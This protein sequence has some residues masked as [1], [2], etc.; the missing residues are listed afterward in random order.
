MPNS[1]TSIGGYAFY[2]NGELTLIEIPNSV[3]SIGEYSF[4]HCYNLTSITIPESV[5]CIGSSAFAGC[6]RITTIEVDKNN[7]IYDSRDNCNAIIE[8]E[9]N[10]L[11]VGCENTIIPNNITSIGGYAFYYSRLTSITI[12]NSVISIGEYAFSYCSALTSIT[13]P[14]S[15]ICIGEYAFSYCSRLTIYCEVDT[16]PS[17]W[18]VNWIYAYYSVKWGYNELN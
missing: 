4:Y 1:V 2:N 6:S 8:T 9:T 18:D 7:P 16:K 11:I 12:P 5:T 14:D 17:G 10:E 15:V 3:T 13:I